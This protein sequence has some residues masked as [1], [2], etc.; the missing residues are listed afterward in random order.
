MRFCTL[1]I[2]H[3]VFS[4]CF[5]PGIFPVCVSVHFRFVM[6]LCFLSALLR[7]MRVYKVAKQN[8]YRLFR[9]CYTGIADSE[10]AS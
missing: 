5:P 7:I 4:D 2:P 3:V 9:H 8:K 1:S 6:C 10:P